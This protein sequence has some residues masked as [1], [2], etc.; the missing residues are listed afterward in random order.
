LERIKEH[1]QRGLMLDD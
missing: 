1:Y